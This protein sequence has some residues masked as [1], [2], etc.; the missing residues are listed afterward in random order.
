MSLNYVI[1]INIIIKL[2]QKIKKIKSIFFSKTGET[3][4][5]IPTNVYAWHL[6]DIEEWIC[7][8]LNRQG[9]G[10]CGQTNPSLECLYT[11]INLDR[12]DQNMQNCTYAA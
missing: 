2:G 11:V 6:M 8:F 10:F 4:T 3:G 9:E 7:L 12:K 1:N 5:G